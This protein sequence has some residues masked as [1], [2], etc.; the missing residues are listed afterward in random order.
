MK[1]H[2]FRIVSG[3]LLLLL[4]F[5][6]VFSLTFNYLLQNLSTVGRAGFLCSVY[7]FN[8]G[9]ETPEKQLDP[10]PKVPHGPNLVLR[11]KGTFILKQR[12]L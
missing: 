8:S 11:V 9:V 6:Q 12:N 1:R 5:T 3:D 4:F 10:S 2:S 7:S